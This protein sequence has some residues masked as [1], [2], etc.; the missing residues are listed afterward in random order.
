VFFFLFIIPVER[1]ASRETVQVLLGDLERFLH[2]LTF[3]SILGQLIVAFLPESSSGDADP[4]KLHD[5][6][7]IMVDGNGLLRIFWPSDTPRTTGSGTII[8][9]RNSESD[10]FVVS[11]LQDVEVLCLGHV[12]SCVI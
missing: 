11:V 4:S 6:D 1:I 5:N 3:N 10:I 2:I 9:W 7:S 12:C 8:G